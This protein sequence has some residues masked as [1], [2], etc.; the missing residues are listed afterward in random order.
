MCDEWEEDDV[1]FNH[2][3]ESQK[4]KEFTSPRSDRKRA[5]DNSNNRDREYSR[6]R[7]TRDRPPREFS[8]RDDQSNGPKDEFLI[9]SFDVR[10]FVVFNRKFYKKVFIF[11]RL[12][13][14]L[15]RADLQFV[16]F[17]A[18]TMCESL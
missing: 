2:S 13:Q 1:P 11:I 4:S 17:K 6:D 16:R 8:R 12:V 15:A 10:H 14:L 7:Q 3:R 5:Y 18:N 9:N